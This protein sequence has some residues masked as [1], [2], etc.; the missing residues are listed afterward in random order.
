M[1][2]VFCNN[3]SFFFLESYIMSN[4]QKST[5]QLL[6][7]KYPTEEAIDPVQAITELLIEAGHSEPSKWTIGL[8]PVASD[9]STPQM[10]KRFLVNRYWRPVLGMVD[11]D[12]TVAR[13]CIMDEGPMYTWLLL[14]KESVVPVIVKHQLPNL[15]W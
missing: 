8:D 13:Y 5:N 1:Q 7:D 3:H 15:S 11:E 14:F 6:R 4:D 2:A 12:T 10:A 9:P